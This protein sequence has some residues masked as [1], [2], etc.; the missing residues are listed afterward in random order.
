MTIVKDNMEKRH[1]FSQSSVITNF[2]GGCCA[3]FPGD[4]MLPSNRDETG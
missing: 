1:H 4:I 2:A 3:S